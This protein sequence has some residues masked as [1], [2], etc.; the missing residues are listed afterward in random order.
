MNGYESL[1][2]IIPMLCVFYVMHADIFENNN[3]ED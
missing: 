3:T 1:I 2:I